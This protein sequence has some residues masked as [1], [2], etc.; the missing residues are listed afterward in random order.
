MPIDEDLRDDLDTEMSNAIGTPYD[1]VSAE[2]KA[3][4]WTAV[5]AAV[6]DQP[7]VIPSGGTTGQTLSKASNTDYDT[8]WVAATVV[9]PEFRSGSGAPAGGLGDIGDHYFDYD[10]EG[11]DLY[12]KTGVTTWTLRSNLEPPMM[13]RG[14]IVMALANNTVILYPTSIRNDDSDT[15][16]LAG[17]FTNTGGTNKFDVFCDFNFQTENIATWT[18]ALQVDTGGG[19]STVSQGTRIIETDAANAYRYAAIKRRLTLAAG[20]KVRVFVTVVGS[21]A[22]AIMNNAIFQIERV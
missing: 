15:S 16:Y 8:E 22:T 6:T 19:Y 13:E 2:V 18:F 14:V 3:G 21:G 11:R 12:E 5:G 4:L 1:A 9:P 20:D 10:S 17:E 7:W